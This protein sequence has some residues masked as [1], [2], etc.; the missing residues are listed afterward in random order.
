M[1]KRGERWQKRRGGEEVGYSIWYW[2]EDKGTQ[3]GSCGRAREE[4]WGSKDC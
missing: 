2:V 1:G 3:N 4:K